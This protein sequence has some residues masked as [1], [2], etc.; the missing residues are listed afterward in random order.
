MADNFDVEE[1][2]ASVETEGSGTREVSAVQ[3][4]LRSRS[5]TPIIPF[6][7]N[8]TVNQEGIVK[9]DGVTILSNNGVISAV[10]GTGSSSTGIPTSICKMLRIQKHGTEVT[11]QWQDPDNTIIDGLTLSSWDRTIIVRKQGSYPT[12]ETDGDVILVN[13]DRNAYDLTGYVD[14]LPDSEN[15][16]FYRAFPISVNGAVNL[17]PEN[18][19]G[20]KVY[21]FIINPNDSNP[22]TRVKYAGENVNFKPAKM[23]FTTGVFDY[24]DWESAFFMGLFKPCMLY[25]AAAGSDKNGTVMEYL[26]PNNYGLTID[27]DASHV[28]DT[29]C[30]A[31]AMVEIGQIWIKEWV[32]SEGKQHIQIASEQIDSSFDCYT[33]IKKDGTYNDYVY[34]AMFDGCNISNKIR[35]LSGQGLCKNVAGNTQITYAKANGDYW[36]VDEYAMRRLINYLLIL[37]GKTTDMQGTFGNGAYT[38]SENGQISSG[39]ANTKGMFYGQTANGVVKV[40]HIEN[41]WGNIWKITNGCIQK[42]GKL[43]YKMCEG[44]HDGSTVENYNDNGNGYIDSG[45][46]ASGTVSEQYIKTMSLVPHL[47]L[48]PNN[49][50]GGS[51]STYYCDGWWSNSSVVGFA[52]FGSHP[53]YGLVVGA[54]AFLVDQAVSYSTWTCGVSLSYKKTS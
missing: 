13:S 28:A 29:S 27:G 15:E 22:A 19:F 50:S 4:L 5:G 7:N 51:S 1:L 10:G 6:I 54:F 26:D 33:H 37:I 25:N 43:L 45:V 30:N 12:D 41:W 3:A 20:N 35:S 23:N 49:A 9:P 21:E 39:Q 34:R 44:T 38:G 36:N 53:G 48:V 24:G 18:K 11:L 42:S 46:T 16:Y 52:R 32:D 47:G 17:D 14:E 40:F 2:E 31:N 8:A